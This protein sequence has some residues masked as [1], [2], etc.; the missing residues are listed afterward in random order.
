MANAREMRASLDG[1]PEVILSHSHAGHTGGLLVLRKAYPGALGTVH[2]GEGFFWARPGSHASSLRRAYAELGGKFVE[3]RA[4]RQIAP[5]LWLTGPVARTHP[6]RNW[7][8]NA[9][10][11][12]PDGVEAEDNVPEDLSLV[13]DTD[14]GLVALSGC[15]H[16][17]IVNTLEH[18]RKQIREA[19]VHA[20]IGG[21]RLFQADDRAL[22][23]TAAKLKEL[24]VAHFLGAHCTGVEAV[25]R[26]RDRAGL[27]RRT[28]VAGATGSAFTLS[29]GID[30]GRLAR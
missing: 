21:W 19:P 14:K 4:A 28:C 2:T 27:T 17:G 29:G 12:R 24:G 23:W 3:H 5:G 1:V 9:R 18:A 10:L 11:R 8:G 16:A 13:A 22:D 26:I 7:S 20:A 25:Y 15:G 30:A 6:E